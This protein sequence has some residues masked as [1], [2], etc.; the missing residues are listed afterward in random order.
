MPRFS[1]D[2]PIYCKAARPIG[3]SAELGLPEVQDPDGLGRV[4]KWVRLLKGPE[5]HYYG[6]VYDLSKEYMELLV[7]NTLR[8]NGPDYRTPLIRQHEPD[9]DRLGDFFQY[10]VIQEPG[11]AEGVYSLHGACVF[12]EDV[13]DVERKVRQGV[14]SSVSVGIWE[15]EDYRDG[16]WREML[17]EVS[18]VSMPH[19]TDARILNSK[20][21]GQKMDPKEFAAAMVAAM[22]E[23]GLVSAAPAPSEGEEEEVIEEEE[24]QSPLE[25]EGDHDKMAAS[26][27]E[28]ENAKLRAAL[29]ANEAKRLKAESAKVFAGAFPV[30]TL[31]EVTDANAALL[32][33]VACSNQ[34]AWKAFVGACEPV[35]A[36]AAP[37]PAKSEDITIPNDWGKIVASGE[38]AAPQS[39]DGPVDLEAINREIKAAGGLREYMKA[40]HGK[41]ILS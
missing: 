8:G 26:R 15:T 2:K 9:G 16:K 29:A 7:A 5:L 37:T 19:V 20:S 41:N 18:L 31:F 11:D 22:V 17:N 30:G 10:A 25:A 39:A 1:K 27:L 33:E 32:F 23:A 36:A 24:E 21:G 14:W 3:E 4:V 28:R 12:L 34:E 13:E 35:K 6:M 40:K 38:V